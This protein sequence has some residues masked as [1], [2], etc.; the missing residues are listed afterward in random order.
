[1][2]RLPYPFKESREACASRDDPAHTSAAAMLNSGHAEKV[3]E[4]TGP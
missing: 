4:L 2:G 1:M 3:F